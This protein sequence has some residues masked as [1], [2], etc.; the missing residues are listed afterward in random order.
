MKKAVYPGSFDPITLGHVDIIE[1]LTVIFDE[2]IVLVA[3]SSQK[4]SA[5]STEERKTLIEKSLA[6]LKNIRVDIFEG[7][8]TDYLKKEKAHVIVRG[9]RAVMD[10]EYEMT[11]A[12][13]NKKLAPDIETMLVFARPEYYYISSRGVKEV[14]A[15]G[16][17]LDG[18]VPLAVVHPLLKK[19]GKA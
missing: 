9:L 7:L 18:L 10:F 5:F 14:A 6:H 2:V 19:L 1:R 12:S 16:G 8:T 13:M 17:S 3:K 15:N 11:M 4:Q